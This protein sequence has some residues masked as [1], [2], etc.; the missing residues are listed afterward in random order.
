MTVRTRGLL[1][2]VGSSIGG[3][4]LYWFLFHFLASSDGRTRVPAYPLALPLVG[5]VIGM[6]ELAT[7]LPFTR[8]DEGWQKLPGYV[9]IPVALVG[10]V[11]LLWAFLWI[12]AKSLGA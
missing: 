9:K 8:I 7:G 10:G 12:V 11:L 3:I 4:A 2:L 6:L 1:T 5:V